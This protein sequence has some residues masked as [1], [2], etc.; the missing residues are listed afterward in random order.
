MKIYITLATL[1]VICGNVQAVQAAPLS[2]GDVIKWLSPKRIAGGSRS[3]LCLPN[4]SVSLTVRPT[5][6]WQ[7]H[8]GAIGLRRSQDEKVFW[9]QTIPAGSALQQLRYSGKALE[10]GQSYD[11]VFF[12]D[13]QGENPLTWQT[14]TTATKQE[15]TL[16]RL[17]LAKLPGTGEAK[18]INRIN[19]LAQQQM[20]GDA[21]SEMLAVRSRSP[22]LEQSLK[23]LGNL[24]E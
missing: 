22:E 20:V 8:I 7:G 5:V 16:T 19:Y 15:Q 4:S 11:W 18:L 10:P 2:W 13:I 14:F 12:D 6:L 17:G 3:P 24:C 21:V 9:R 23:K 1:L